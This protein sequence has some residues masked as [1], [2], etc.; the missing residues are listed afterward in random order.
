[1][2]D[3]P[4]LFENLRYDGI[5][6]TYFIISYSIEF[7]TTFCL[8]LCTLINMATFFLMLKEEDMSLHIIPSG[9]F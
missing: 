6:K 5:K 2:D 8:V 9:C 1:M 3:T 7:I 4:F